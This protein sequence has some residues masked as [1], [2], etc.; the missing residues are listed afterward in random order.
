MMGLPKERGDGQ[1]AALQPDSLPAT[2]SRVGVFQYPKSQPL[3]FSLEICFSSLL[4]SFLELEF[5]ATEARPS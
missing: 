3:P 2:L 4:L 1:E 5:A